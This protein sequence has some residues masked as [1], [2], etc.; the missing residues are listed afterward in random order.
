VV[1]NGVVLDRADRTGADPAPSA[2]A[3]NHKAPG[4]GAG[5]GLTGS[6]NRPYLLALG[7]VVEKK[8]FDLLLS[9][10]GAIDPDHRSA[11]LVIGG[12]GA[13]LP[14]LEQLAAD[15]GVADQVHFVGRLSRE[16]VASAMA[17][18]TAFIM[19]SRLEPFGIVIL[20]G[21]RA[22]V[23]VVATNRG[24]PPEF[25]EDGT[26]GVLVDPFDTAQFA[27]ALQALLDDPARRSGIAAAGHQ[28]VQAF[29]WPVITEQYRRIYR[30]VLGDPEVSPAPS[31]PPA[32]ATR[33]GESVR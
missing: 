2:R 14:G 28:R 27:A 13:A 32:R 9:A 22:G 3:G 10:Y 7:R 8:G 5:S 23:A 24:G 11:D 30:S 18:A 26:T 25:V 12:A 31:G 29:D 6:R 20:E 21:W 4:G 15:L 19:P 33:V 16:E 1:F 17:G